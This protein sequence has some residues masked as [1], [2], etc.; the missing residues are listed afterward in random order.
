VESEAAAQA[1]ALALVHL[2]P[3]LTVE[4]RSPLFV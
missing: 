1:V 3:G 2:Q 4:R